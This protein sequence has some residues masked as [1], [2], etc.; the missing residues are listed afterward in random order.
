MRSTARSWRTSAA[1]CLQAPA[2]T[3]STLMSIAEKKEPEPAKPK[4]E[5]H[6]TMKKRSWSVSPAVFPSWASPSSTGSCLVGTLFESS[7]TAKVKLFNQYL[8]GFQENCS[9]APHLS[10]KVIFVVDFNLVSHGCYWELQEMW[11][12][13]RR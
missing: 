1:C 8:F 11:R 10:D 4:L 3:R 2:P 12:K 6:K 9:I 13:W 5:P 7:S